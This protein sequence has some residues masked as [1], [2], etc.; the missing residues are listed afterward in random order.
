MRDLS[1]AIKQTEY[2]RKPKSEHRTLRL[3]LVLLVLIVLIGVGYLLQINSLGT[4]GYQI[5][6][7]EVKLKQL[8]AEHK[9]LEVQASSLQSIN[10]IE[11]EAKKLNFVPT[12]NVTYIKDGDFALK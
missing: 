6:Q 9:N 3:N 7:L 8:E 2:I 5:R 12:G 10:R 11:Q 4:R 1:L